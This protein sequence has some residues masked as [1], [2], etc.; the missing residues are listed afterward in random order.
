MKDYDVIKKPLVTEK[1]VSSPS[2]TG[3]FYA[4]EVARQATKTD[5]KRAVEKLFKVHVVKV[6]T[7]IVCGKLKKVGR[8]QG[9]RSNWKKAMVSLK[10]GEKIEIFEGV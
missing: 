2:S 9:Y 10:A 5:I 3:S 7:A 4:F 1:A 6:N 8:S